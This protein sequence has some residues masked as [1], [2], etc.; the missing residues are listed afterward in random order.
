LLGILNA[1][2]RD[3]KPWVDVTKPLLEGA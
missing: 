1:I 3:G 2:V